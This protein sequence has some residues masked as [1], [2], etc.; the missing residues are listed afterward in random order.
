MKARSTAR[1]GGWA[2]LLAAGLA[3]ALPALAATDPRAARYYEDALV[4][5]EKKDLPG[6]IIQLKNAL[7][8]DRNQLPVQTLL[9]KV[10]LANGD[11][12][13][14]EVAFAEAL[15]L[16]VNRAEL[17]LPMAETYIALGKQRQLLTEATF[18]PAGLPRDTQI[19]ILLLRASAHADIGDTRA[20]LATIG[21]ARA[22][23]PRSSASFAAEVPIRIRA[24]QLT[25]CF[26]IVSHFTVSI[27][28]CSN[29]YIT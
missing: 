23:D 5:Y 24:G 19:R 6:A 21:E 22:I 20:A 25:G 8:I 7:Q 3:G 15:R 14:A 13:A 4:R 16:G 12:I 27:K 18:N 26:W 29:G 1:L 9:G 11:A 10:L 17:V 2:L 28:I